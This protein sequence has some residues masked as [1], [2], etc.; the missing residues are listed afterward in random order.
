M[1]C[2]AMKS[3]SRC[4]LSVTFSDI[5]IYFYIFLNLIQILINASRYPITLDCKQPLL[6]RLTTTH[7]LWINN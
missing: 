2:N 6:S 3:L 5:S 1:Q 7:K 4:E